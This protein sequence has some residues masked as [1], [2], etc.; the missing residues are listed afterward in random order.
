MYQILNKFDHYIHFTMSII[1]HG[2]L[3]LN[4]LRDDNS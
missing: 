2:F 3:T 1:L 4:Y